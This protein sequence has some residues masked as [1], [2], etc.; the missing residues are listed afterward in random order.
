MARCSWVQRIPTSLVS[1]SIGWCDTIF[2]S[3][4]NISPLPSQHSWLYCP[5][6]ARGSTRSTPLLWCLSLLCWSESRCRVNIQLRA[7]WVR[8]FAF[9]G[10][11]CSAAAAPIPCQRLP[12]TRDSNFSNC[13][14]DWLP[15]KRPFH[16][17]AAWD[18]RAD[19]RRVKCIRHCGTI[20]STLPVFTATSNSSTDNRCFANTAP[21]WTFH[22]KRRRCPGSVSRKLSR[23][24]RC[25]R[26]QCAARHVLCCLDSRAR[27]TH[28]LRFET[29]LDAPTRQASL[30]QAAP[31]A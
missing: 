20:H 2:V 23:H 26:R 27:V 18:T 10:L 7:P 16:S 5:L 21:S 15:G 9:P 6:V 28:R 4:V 1:F 24:R 3:A 12:A 17:F 11:R 30:C 25:A 19:M 14:G 29:Y 8:K 13:N 22:G 31:V